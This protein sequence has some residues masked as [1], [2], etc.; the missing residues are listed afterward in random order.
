MNWTGI[1]IANVNNISTTIRTGVYWLRI[2][3][4]GVLAKP[5][6]KATTLPTNTTQIHKDTSVTLIMNKNEI[7]KQTSK[8][9]R[10]HERCLANIPVREFSQF[11]RRSTDYIAT[12]EQIIDN[13]NASSLR[14]TLLGVF[15][16]ES[17]SHVQWSVRISQSVCLVQSKT[18]NNWRTS[19][20]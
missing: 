13:C 11:S 8:V 16:W 4:G 12:K 15:G 20:W 17:S 14:C 5:L 2:P 1:V 18:T 10:W 19:V 9:P 6:S 7:I 3:I